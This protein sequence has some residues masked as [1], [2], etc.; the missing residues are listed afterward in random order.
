MNDT[1][2]KLAMPHL[3][4]AVSSSAEAI[5]LVATDGTPQSD[6][7]ISVARRLAGPGDYSVR[8][9]AVVDHASMPWGT[10]EGSLVLQYERGE[11]EEARKRMTAQ[12]TRLGDPDWPAEVK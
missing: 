2:Q 1:S 5:L 12:V 11:R 3:S 6:A 7:A 10:V 4:A 8:V 9:V